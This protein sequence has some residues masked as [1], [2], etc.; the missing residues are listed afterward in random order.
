MFAKKKKR[1]KIVMMFK[2]I[3]TRKAK[4]RNGNPAIVMFGKSK[5]IINAA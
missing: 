5:N 2:S 3:M 1:W 4:E